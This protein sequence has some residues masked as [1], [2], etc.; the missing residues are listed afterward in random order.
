MEILHPQKFAH[1]LVFKCRGCSEEITA[2]RKSEY[3]NREHIARLIFDLKC[4]TCGWSANLSGI[5]AMGH[6]VTYDR[7][8]HREPQSSPAA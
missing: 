8:A 6:S 2:V 5:S 7:A 1:V 4:G 3:M